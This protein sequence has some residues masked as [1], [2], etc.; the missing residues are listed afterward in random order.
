MKERG[1][2]MNGERFDEASENGIRFLKTLCLTHYSTF[3]RLDAR[4]VERISA[5]KE[6]TK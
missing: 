6:R 3:E 2:A 1:K 4:I 5:L